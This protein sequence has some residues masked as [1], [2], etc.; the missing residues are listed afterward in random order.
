MATTVT[1]IIRPET[2]RAKT[3]RVGI[4]RISPRPQL[5]RLTRAIVATIPMWAAV[6]TAATAVATMAVTAAVTAVAAEAATAAAVTTV[7]ATV[8][9]AMA[10]GITVAVETN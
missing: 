2:A 6:T 5:N 7:D 4:I 9:A 10:V 3:I 8:V 1:E